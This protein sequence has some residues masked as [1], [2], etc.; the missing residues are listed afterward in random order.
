MTNT[1]GMKEKGWLEFKYRN[2]QEPIRFPV[3][4]VHGAADGP[5]LVVLGGMQ[6]W[7]LQPVL[8][9]LGEV[10]LFLGATGLT[11]FIDQT[12]A[13][14]DGPIDVEEREWVASGR[15]SNYF[16]F[17]DVYAEYGWKSGYDFPPVPD[18]A[19]HDGVHQALPRRTRTSGTG[20]RRSSRDH[21]FRD[22]GLLQ[23][24]K[25]Q[26]C[27]RATRLGGAP[28]WRPPRRAHFR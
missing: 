3:G 12:G 21:A 5:T 13:G 28:L 14:P 2:T 23:V 10:P 25:C 6:K 4:T 7:W 1:P 16:D 24:G 11:Y 9:S 17:G 19:Q 26:P 8:A 20:R 22:P 18:G 27:G 15:L